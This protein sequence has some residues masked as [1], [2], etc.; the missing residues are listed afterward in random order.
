[1]GKD[2]PIGVFEYLFIATRGLFEVVVSVRRIEER[3]F[4]FGIGEEGG[5]DFCKTQGRL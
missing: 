4:V 5:V 3:I 1:M 2:D